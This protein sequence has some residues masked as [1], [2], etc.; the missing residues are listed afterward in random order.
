MILLSQNLLKLKFLNDYFENNS[1]KMEKE[2]KEEKE[3][4]YDQDDS[5][6]NVFLVYYAFNCLYFHFWEMQSF[7][8]VQSQGVKGVWSVLG[9]YIIFISQ[10]GSDQEGRESNFCESCLE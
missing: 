7:L 1:W 2:E 5:S 8:R 9:T 10:C 6:S 3:R 4:R